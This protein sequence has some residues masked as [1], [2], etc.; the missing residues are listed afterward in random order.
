MF[1]HIELLQ[2]QRVDIVP[3][4]RRRVITPVVSIEMAVMRPRAPEAVLSA[5]HP[6]Y[7]PPK[8]VSAH[9][10]LDDIIAI[11]DLA[12]VTC[13][14]YVTNMI[15]QVILASAY[16]IDAAAE[17]TGNLSGLELQLD[18]FLF[19]NM[20]IVKVYFANSSREASATAF[21]W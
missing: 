12:N 4:K 7:S 15:D 17:I 9:R 16:F 2:E 20:S 5:R 3:N 1:R 18:N 14:D 6:E 8:G 19:S 21:P 11:G 10:R 13:A